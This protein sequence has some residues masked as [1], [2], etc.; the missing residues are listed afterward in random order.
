MSCQTS[1]DD[2]IA[3]TLLAIGLFS[4]SLVPFFLLVDA[5]FAELGRSLAAGAAA[6]VRPAREVLRDA[7]ALLILLTTSP[8]GA[9]S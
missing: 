1:A 5:D 3:C 2:V 6:A 7:A 4:G 9:S 8:K